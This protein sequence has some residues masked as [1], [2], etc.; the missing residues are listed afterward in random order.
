MIGI[1]FAA[2]M[3]Q[4]QKLL[5]VAG[6][7]IILGL[8]LGLSYCQGRTDGKNVVKLENEKARNEALRRAFTAGEKAAETR[9]ADQRR[10]L[11]AEKKYEQVIAAAP[12]G[13]NSPASIALGCERLRRA[14]FGDS[15]LPVECRPSG[16]N[17]A[18]AQAGN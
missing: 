11:E 3:T 7:I 4:A 8:L 14:G 10:Q 2:G 17:G 5:R 6:F 13:R 1:G 15:V 16:G 9:L 18:K 12:G